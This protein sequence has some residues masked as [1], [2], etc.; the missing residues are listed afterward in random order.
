M[1]TILLEKRDRLALVTINRPKALNALNY[2]VFSELES[3]FRDLA[4]DEATAAV[5]ITGSGE[6]AFVAGAD[7]KEL[8]TLDT[9]AARQLAERGQRIFSLIENCPKPV[10]AAVNGFA[11]GGGCE[12]AMACHMR[13]ASEKARFGLP[14]VGLGLIPGYAG[15]QRLPRLV[16]KGI[17]MELVLTGDMISAARAHEIGLVNH[18]VAPEAL[19][20]KALGMAAAIQSKGPLAV[21][22]AMEAVNRGY[23]MA[24][25]DGERYEAA[26]FGLLAG[27]EDTK[28]GLAAFIEKRKPEF[29]GR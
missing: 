24:R 15:T 26:L 7:I 20:E 12:L 25:E 10:I 27:T 11:L 13:V 16:G 4:A 14:E 21:R 29:K 19:E 18:V 28:E 1:E 2:Q 23:E 9:L 17:A 3:C 6:K 22:H 5:V 8:A